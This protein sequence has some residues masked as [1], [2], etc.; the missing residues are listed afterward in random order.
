M[1]N[2]GPGVAL[3]VTVE[4]DCGRS[5]SAALDTEEVRLGDIPPG[6]FALSFKVMVV[7][8]A[9]TVNMVM[10]VNWNQLFDEQMSRWFLMS[11]AA[12]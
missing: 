7:E 1:V 10:Q 3:D 11:T 4:L 8:P 6:E 9:A 5:S 2:D 12:R